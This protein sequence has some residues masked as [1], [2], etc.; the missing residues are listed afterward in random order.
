MKKEF[1][2]FHN[3][4]LNDYIQFAD[5][6]A[7]IF[8]SINGIVLG[9]IFSQLNKLKSINIMETNQF[10]LVLSIFLLLIAYVFLFLVI[11]PRRKFKSGNGIIFWY[12][13]S[14]YKEPSKY[15]EKV[16]NIDN[17]ELV[18]AITEQNFYLSKTAQ[19]KYNSLFW[20]LLFSFIG[21]GS[22]VLYCLLQILF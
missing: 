3:K 11:F 14:T 19:K 5:T 17:D 8:I 7:A 2:T 20:S 4:Y 22:L 9:Y 1:S 18:N 6:K 13:V 21:Y 16:E 15:V 10:F 12:D